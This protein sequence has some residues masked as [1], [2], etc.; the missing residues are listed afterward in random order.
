MA[1]AQ[2]WL[3]C[4]PPATQ[5][6]IGTPLLAWLCRVLRSRESAV[7]SGYAA[8]AGG[9]TE[10]RSYR[11]HGPSISFPPMCPSTHR[12][13][14]PVSTA[15]WA[16]TRASALSHSLTPLTPLP[17]A[18]QVLKALLDRLRNEITR[19]TAVKAF[20]AI[21]RSPLNI[22]LGPG[23]REREGE[24][25]GERRE[26][27]RECVSVFVCVV[28]RAGVR[29]SV[30]ALRSAPLAGRPPGQPCV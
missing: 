23:K 8:R 3:P 27:E 2:H 1:M 5:G 6:G 19:L 11:A 15:R 14:D 20:A 24:R 28:Y 21:A 16:D 4:A 13:L 12:K 22:D 29:W 7:W 30:A 18:P 17:P 10:A 26:R 9:E 25:G